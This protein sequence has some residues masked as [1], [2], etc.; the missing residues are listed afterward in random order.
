VDTNM[1]FPPHKL[2]LALTVCFC[3]MLIKNDQ[4]RNFRGTFIMY[5]RTIPMVF[6]LFGVP[7]GPFG[8]MIA[9]V[10]YFA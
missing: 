3:K 9:P 7:M 10:V 5:R 4:F 6:C 8:G 1:L 2:S